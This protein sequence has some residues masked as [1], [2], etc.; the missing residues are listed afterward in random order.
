M[1]FLSADKKKTHS[2]N[3]PEKIPLPICSDIFRPGAGS[4]E[5]A[6]PGESKKSAGR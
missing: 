3:S 2:V 5:A 6:A 4:G 1:G